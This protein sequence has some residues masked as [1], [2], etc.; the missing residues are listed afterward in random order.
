MC[1][2]LQR[3]EEGIS[4]AGTGVTG[5]WEPSGVSAGNWTLEEE[6]V[7]LTAEA[8][9]QPSALLSPLNL[10]SPFK[11]AI[12]RPCFYFSWVMFQLYRPRV[13]S[14]PSSQVASLPSSWFTVTNHHSRLQH[15]PPP[16]RRLC[17]SCY[18][19]VVQSTSAEYTIC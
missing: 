19:L 7:L 5:G 18:Q 6:L 15:T 10:T 3:P 16:C 17:H 13:S 2:C 9:L 14:W 12:S 4:A 8:P 1:R 11:L